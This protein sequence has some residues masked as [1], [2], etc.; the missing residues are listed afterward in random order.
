MSRVVSWS[1]WVVVVTAGCAPAYRPPAPFVPLLQEK[2]D[3]QI[4]GHWGTGGLQADGAYALSDHFAMRGGA[5]LAGYTSQGMYLVGNVGV[6]G[7]GAFTDSIYWGLTGTV[8]GGYSRGI[9]DLSV[10]VI[11]TSG[12][13]TT[14]ESW[15]NS[16]TLMTGAVRWES[17]IRFDGNAMAGVQIGPT[18]HG[19]IHDAQSDGTGMGQ[20]LLM[21]GAAIGRIGPGS[22]PIAFEGSLGFAWPLYLDFE[23]S[24]VPLPF[25]MALGITVEP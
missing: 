3:S 1:V 13:T 5:Q 22:A 23:D 12:T 24:G 6:G 17:G 2:G 21:E 19:L 16:G 18:W 8:G 4:A 7:Y 15:R 10:S 9:T 20:G 14:T 11:T 25:V